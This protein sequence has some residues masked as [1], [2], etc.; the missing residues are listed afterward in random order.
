MGAS[1]VVGIGSSRACNPFEDCDGNGYAWVAARSLRAKG[2]TVTVAQL[3]I[4]AVVLGPSTQA[5]AS[6]Y[7]IGGIP[8][9]ILQSEAPFVRKDATFVTVFAGANDV[10]V[11][12]GALGSGASFSDPGSFI[13]Q[14]VTNIGSDFAALLAA[15][16]SRATT[17]RVIVLNLPNMAAT[18]YRAGSS[19]ALKQ[20]TQRASVGITTRVIN[21]MANVTVVDLMCDARFYQPSTF[22]SDG[23][24]PSDA[25]YAII[26][27]EIVNAMTSASYPAPKASC[28]QMFLY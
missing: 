11:I 12:T 17:A 4:P 26:A 25:G 13:D 19:L 6:L 27:A 10:N 22:S 23:F 7:G 9:N 1:D 14:Q 15:I 2:F 20:A 3:G 18:P 16:R 21:P 28:P 5:L 8:G 24:H